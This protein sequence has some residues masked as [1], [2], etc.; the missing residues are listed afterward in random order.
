MLGDLALLVGLR[1]DL[2]FAGPFELTK[3][4]AQVSVLMAD[5]K[6]CPHP[7]SYKIAATYQNKGTFKTMANI[8]RHRG[9]FGLYTGFKLHLCK[10]QTLS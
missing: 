10:W 8:M 4:S 1:T 6:N 3:L 5:R 2:R 7:E 9:P